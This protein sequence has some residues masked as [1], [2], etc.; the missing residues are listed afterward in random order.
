MPTASPTDWQLLSF[1]DFYLAPVSSQLETSIFFM[2]FL[3]L[4]QFSTAI[5]PCL[6]ICRLLTEYFVWRLFLSVVR[7]GASDRINKHVPALHGNSRGF[8]H[9]VHHLLLYLKRT[10]SPRLTL[11]PLQSLC[12]GSLSLSQTASAIVDTAGN[13][14]AVNPKHVES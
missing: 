7:S 6:F 12:Y 3:A 8:V 9:R 2:L 13:T 5:V 1:P 4:F 10:N 14:V 11:S